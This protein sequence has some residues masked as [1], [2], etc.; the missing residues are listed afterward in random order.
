MLHTSCSLQRYYFFFIYA[1]KIAI[2]AKKH[3]WR[4]Y[5]YL[6]TVPKKRQ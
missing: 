6:N 3:K 4:L 2:C 1:N 5:I